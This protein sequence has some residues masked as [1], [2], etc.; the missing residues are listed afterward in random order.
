MNSLWRVSGGVLGFILSTFSLQACA[1]WADQFVESRLEYNF[2]DN[3]NQRANRDFREQDHWLELQLLGGRVWQIA[4]FDRLTFSGLIRGRTHDRFDGLDHMRYQL[5]VAW[6]HKWGIGL[7]K[8]W[9]RLSVNGAWQDFR[10]EFRD[11]VSLDAEI[12]WGK[13]LNERFTWQWFYQY[14]F[15]HGLDSDIFDQQVHTARTQLSYLLNNSGILSISYAFESGEG[16]R[17]VP[18]VPGQPV[19]SSRI[20]QDDVFEGGLIKNY[21]H[22]NH[23][24]LDYNHV[25][26]D[27]IL[28]LN[29]GYRLN[30]NSNIAALSLTA[31]LD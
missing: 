27:G 14:I 20:N 17:Y 11:F 31:S 7:S 15:R 30:G 2:N 24:A 19:V 3:I 21:R 18:W 6:R 12:E 5:G 23:Y 22:L 28:A 13:R 26:L 10:S 25:L 29:I 1:E 16:A 9:S 4:S 8:P